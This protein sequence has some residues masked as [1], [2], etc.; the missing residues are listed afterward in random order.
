MA[1]VLPHTSIYGIIR[2][3]NQLETLDGAATKM[4]AREQ[5]RG[6]ANLR[7]LLTTVRT[8]HYWTY[9][10]C[11]GLITHY[12]LALLSIPA[13]THVQTTIIKVIVYHIIH[14]NLSWLYIFNL[15]YPVHTIGNI[16]HQFITALYGNSYLLICTM[17][18]YCIHMICFIICVYTA[19]LYSIH[20]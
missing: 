10:N 11:T 1:A 5:S 4:A 12:F 13:C 2:F 17:T 3:Q 15:I 16:W 18:I 7:W 14:V 8:L 9:S 6:A 20:C 19:Y